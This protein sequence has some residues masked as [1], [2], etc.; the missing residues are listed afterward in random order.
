MDCLVC[1]VVYS[2]GPFSLLFFGRFG[3]LLFVSVGDC[4]FGVLIG[5][6]GFLIGSSVLFVFCFW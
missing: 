6:I 1:V 3:L 5:G 4:S 2:D